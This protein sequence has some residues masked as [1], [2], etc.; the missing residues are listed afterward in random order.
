[1]DISST[2]RSPFINKETKTENSLSF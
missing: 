1:L 2:A